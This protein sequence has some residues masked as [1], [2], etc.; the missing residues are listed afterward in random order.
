VRDDRKQSLGFTRS[1]SNIDLGFLV[2]AWPRSCAPRKR[3]NN[4]P[5]PPSRT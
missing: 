4:D 5:L 1:L 2:R 3:S